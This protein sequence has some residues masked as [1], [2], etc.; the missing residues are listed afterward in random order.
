MY[1]RSE[2]PLRDTEIRYTR[3]QQLLREKGSKALFGFVGRRWRMRTAGAQLGI[4]LTVSFPIRTDTTV[5]LSIDEAILGQLGNRL[6]GSK[7]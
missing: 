6:F 2:M 7:Q 3:P 4:R 1:I 5:A